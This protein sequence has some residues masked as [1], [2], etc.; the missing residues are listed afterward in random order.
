MAY[1]AGVV[2]FLAPFLVAIGAIIHLHAVPWILLVSQDVSPPDINTVP[3]DPVHLVVRHGISGAEITVTDR[4][5]H[6]A[7]LYMGDVGK[8][9]AV[10][11]A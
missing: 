7:H 6:V 1:K 3:A 10:G 11:L 2:T 9:D 4:T 5:F 8:I